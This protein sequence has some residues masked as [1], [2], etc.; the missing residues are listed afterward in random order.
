[1]A[2]V[3]GTIADNILS[4]TNGRDLIRGFGGMDH[5]ETKGGNDRVSGSGDINTGRGN[6]AFYSVRAMYGNWLNDN[7]FTDVAMR[8]GND[9]VVMTDHDPLHGGTNYAFGI[10]IKLGSG[11]DTIIYGAK[12]FA[13]VQDLGSGADTA[14]ILSDS[15]GGGGSGGVR[16]SLGGEGQFGIYTDPQSDTVHLDS[17]TPVT[18]LYQ[19]GENDQIVLYGTDMT[20]QDIR[21][22]TTFIHNDKSS[23]IVTLDNGNT[24]EVVKGWQGYLGADNLTIVDRELSV[25][26]KVLIG[27]EATLKNALFLSGAD[28]GVKAEGKVVFAGAGDDIVRGDTRNDVFYGDGGD[29]RLLGNRGHDLLDGG[30]GDDRLIGGAGRD[31]IH[32]GA[33]EDFVLAGRG[34]DEIIFSRG[35]GTL[36]GGG[37]RDRFEL[38]DVLVNGNPDLKLKGGSGTDTFAIEGSYRYPAIKLLDFRPGQDVIEL[39]ARDGWSTSDEVAYVERLLSRVGTLDTTK[40]DDF[41]GAYIHYGNLNIELRGVDSDALSVSD[42]IFG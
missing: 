2:R 18:T 36:K 9:L 29:D 33:G 20:L 37:G 7:F 35:G 4:G 21:Q 23:L 6:D 3:N 22:R 27:N 34:D 17:N 15:I 12:T 31:V 13:D 16:L 40:G 25:R 30:M 24:L 38:D 39:E 8:A 28:N 5:I 26:E 11:R 10:D 41:D 32:T 42:F 14:F 19:F 1:M